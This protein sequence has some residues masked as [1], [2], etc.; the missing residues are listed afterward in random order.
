MSTTL[1]LLDDIIDA[2]DFNEEY[3]VQV[4]D[5]IQWGTWILMALGNNY[6]LPHSINHGQRIFV[7]LRVRNIAEFKLFDDSHHDGLGKI[8]RLTT[9]TFHE[10]NIEDMP[11]LMDDDDEDMPALMDDDDDDDD[12]SSST[13]PESTSTSSELVGSPI[14]ESA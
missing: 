7:K 14:H 13:S 12:E 4:F 6:R 3:Q 9:E 10:S 11:G 8:M 5:L 2:F 1:V